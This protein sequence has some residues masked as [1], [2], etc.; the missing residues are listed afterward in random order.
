MTTA[1]ILTLGRLGLS[2]VYFAL[3]L[4]LP[5]GAWLVLPLA[6]LIAAGVTDI[7]DGRI[8]RRTNTV[9]DFGRVADAF[10]DRV[11]AIGSYVIFLKWGLVD[12]W[13]VL[14]VL[15]R[16]LLVGAMRNLADSRGLKFKSTIFGK[17]KFASQF[18]ACV[19]VILY[20]AFFAGSGW[21]LF[22]MD[23]VV[24]VSVANT[25]FSGIV[26]FANYRRLVGAE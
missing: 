2:L 14:V 21:A 24:Y 9:T 23:A 4:A 18:A 25:A 22:C 7:L 10:I 3:L 17:T 12:A 6:L 8:A 20:R 5:A 13:M 1:N 26:Y 15:V 11:L 19:A 16:E